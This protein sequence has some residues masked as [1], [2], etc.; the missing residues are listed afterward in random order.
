MSKMTETVHILFL[1][2]PENGQNSSTAERCYT[3]VSV[4]T[5][6]IY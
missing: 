6:T 2:T 4:K 5:E 3:Y 1:E